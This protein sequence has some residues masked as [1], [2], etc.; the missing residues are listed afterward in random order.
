MAD[1]D[2]STI[3]KFKGSTKKVKLALSHTVRYLNTIKT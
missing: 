3:A 2:R 1:R